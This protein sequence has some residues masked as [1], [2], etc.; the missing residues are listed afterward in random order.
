MV[1][2][3]R[4]RFLQTVCGGL[5]AT[6]VGA[7]T[8]GGEKTPRGPNIVVFTVDD[9]DITSVN[10]YGNPLPNLTPNMDR[11]A[12]EGMRFEHAHVSAAVCMPCRQSYMTGLHS[13]HN[14]SFGFVEVEPGAFPSLP[15][16]LMEHGYYAGS[17]GKGRDY[18]AFP[19]D[20][21]IGGLGGQGW[22][23]RKPEGFYREAKAMIHEA[24]EAGKPFYLGINTSDPH[25]PFVGSQQEEEHVKRVR[26]QYPHAPDF[27]EMEPVCSEDEVPL[28]PYLPDL[29]AIRK[30]T[31]QYLTAVKRG[32]DALGQIMDLI[33]EE[34]LTD[35]TLFVFFSDHAASMPTAK[36][37][38]YRHSSA[39]PLIVRW[40]GKVEP[41]TVDDTHMVSTLDFMSTFLELLDIPIPEPQ[42]GRSML[43][44]WRG[45]RQS[46][47]DFVMTTHNYIWP[48]VQVFPMRAVHTKDWSYVF[49]PWSDGLNRREHT[50]NQSGLTMDA[51]RDAAVTDEA[52]RERLNYMLLR[53]RDELFDLKADPYSFDNLA[54][55]QA[56]QSKME[57][58]QA[59]LAKEMERT[60]DTLLPYLVEKTG[61]PEE[62]DVLDEEL[63]P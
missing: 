39:I 53:Q 37:N 22:Y 57:E 25:R 12:S 20:G 1:T 9:M 49:N 27:P 44:L 10:C 26:E 55:E 42:D 33:D 4:R 21:F 63:I 11:L 31:V 34:G 30:E 58:M 60:N 3:N 35:E 43:P 16:L 46:D 36:Q 18:Q 59:L 6:G 13:H 51:I 52:M 23:N 38:C 41:G 29:P 61:Y 40:P 8:I 28:L 54:E 50:E 19:W 62:W 48:G 5:A 14:G 45:E 2:W 47:R 56:Y 24:R 17:I 32:D 7:R 15:E